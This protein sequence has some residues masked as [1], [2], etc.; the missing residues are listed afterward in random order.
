[1]KKV[2]DRCRV[3]REID[4]KVRGVDFKGHWDRCRGSVG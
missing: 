4:V 1:M 2:T 3:G